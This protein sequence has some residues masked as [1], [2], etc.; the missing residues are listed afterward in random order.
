MIILFTKFPKLDF[1]AFSITPSTWLDVVFGATPYELEWMR[2]ETFRFSHTL[3]GT[4]SGK[5]WKRPWKGEIEILSDRKILTAQ[6]DVCGYVPD[7]VRMEIHRDKT[8]YRFTTPSEFFEVTVES[9][10]THMVVG[11]K[12]H[13]TEN[14]H[15]DFLW[16]YL[17]DNIEVT[18]QGY[19][20]PPISF[21]S[22]RECVIPLEGLVPPKNPR[23]GAQHTQHHLFSLYTKQGFPCMLVDGALHFL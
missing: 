20:A 19:V 5:D 7:T 23:W 10:R 8:L 21:L 14:R 13:V 11:G 17:H 3:N 4:A 15:R 2:F 16:H 12:N 18:P 22:S 1:D 6:E 9:G